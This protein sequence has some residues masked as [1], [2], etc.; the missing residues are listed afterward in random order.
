VGTKRFLDSEVRENNG[1]EVWLL[2]QFLLVATPYFTPG[3]RW[4]PRAH[5][6]LIAGFA[7]S[8]LVSAL[9]CALSCFLLA[10][11]FAFSRARSI[12]WALL[13][14]FFGWV[15]LLLMLA[16]QEWP[17]RIVCPKCRKLRVVIRDACEHC[18]APHAAP[19]PD[20]T[21]I[22][23]PAVELRAGK[24]L[25]RVLSARLLRNA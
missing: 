6:D 21:E 17:A 2:H 11:R 24:M 5:P 22:F 23:E 20:G 12:G 19:A 13:G 10:R 16:V 14:C 3:V 25:P 9:A 4:L 7:A 18:G 1:A 15:G 8:M